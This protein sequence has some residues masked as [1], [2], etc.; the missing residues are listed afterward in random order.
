MHIHAQLYAIYPELT[1]G[2]I[3]KNQIPT[4]DQQTQQDFL[5]WSKKRQIDAIVQDNELYHH[6]LLS[7]PSKPYIVYYQ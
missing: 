1:I 7:V 4:V 3:K 6:K 5:K 2:Q